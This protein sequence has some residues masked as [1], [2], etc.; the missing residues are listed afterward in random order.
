MTEKTFEQWLQVYGRAWEDKNT[1][2]FVSGFAADANYYWT[3]FDTPQKGIDE[4]NKAFNEAIASQEGIN[5]D[6]QIL[7]VDNDR[8]LC[9]WWCSFTRIA[10]QQLINLD[11]IFLIKF[12]EENLCTEFR[13]WWHTDEFM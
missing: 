13:E 3:P 5:F 8:G 2:K 10:T 7:N 9:Q 12:N 4:I 11:G 1:E 6:S